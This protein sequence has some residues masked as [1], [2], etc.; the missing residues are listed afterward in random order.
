[1]IEV[2]NTVT[3]VGNN[4]RVAAAMRPKI[5]TSAPAAFMS[6]TVVQIAKPLIEGRF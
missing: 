4:A 2:P 1:M 5:R 6:K 3:L